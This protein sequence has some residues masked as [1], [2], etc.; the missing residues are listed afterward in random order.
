MMSG[1]PRP[2]PWL[3]RRVFL[4]TSACS[5]TSSALSGSDSLAASVGPSA[6]TPVASS[7]AGA[8]AELQ[9]EISS[10]G[11]VPAPELGAAH[12]QK[13]NQAE[14]GLS[15]R[16]YHTYADASPFT[17]KSGSP[18]PSWRRQIHHRQL[19]RSGFLHCRLIC[20]FIERTRTAE[21]IHLN[22]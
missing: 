22:T 20:S 18:T 17:A 15:G 21:A 8:H 14:R 19:M 3:A 16:S 9:H 10:E 2:W 12:V 1:W 11:T 6:S 5:E 13:A 4:A 7:G